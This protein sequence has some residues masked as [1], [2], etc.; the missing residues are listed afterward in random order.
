MISTSKAGDVS[1]MDGKLMIVGGE[2]SVGDLIGKVQCY[3]PVQ[4]NWSVYCE[5]PMPLKSK[6]IIGNYVTSSNS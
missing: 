1:V 5:L 3:D 4:K 2:D 6:C